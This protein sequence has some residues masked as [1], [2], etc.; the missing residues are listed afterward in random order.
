MVNVNSSALDVPVTDHT[1]E[2]CQLMAAAADSN[3]P[4][5]SGVVEY[6]KISEKLRLVNAIILIEFI[7]NTRCFLLLAVYLISR[8]RLILIIDV[9]SF[10]SIS[11]MSA[12]IKVTIL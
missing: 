6:H 8:P 11:F 9:I 1:Y 7:I 12:G 2:D 4:K 10:K 3:L 5:N